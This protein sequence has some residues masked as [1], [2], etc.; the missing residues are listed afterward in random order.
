MTVA[1]HKLYAPKGIG[2][3]YTR[4]SLEVSPS[5]FSIHLFESLTSLSSH[6]P[7]LPVGTFVSRWGTRKGEETRNRKCHSLLCI[8]SVCFFPFLSSPLNCPYSLSIYSLSPLSACELAAEELEDR[9]MHLKKTRDALYE[10]LSSSLPADSFHVN[11]H[12]PFALP[13]TL[14]L[15]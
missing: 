6:L 3:L 7:F 13:N 1:G 2:A 9:A 11:T 15:W 5:F 4:K 8:G 12:F 10:Q 14:S